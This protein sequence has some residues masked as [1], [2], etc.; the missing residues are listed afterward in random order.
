MK[1][2]FSQHDLLKTV[3]GKR[4]VLQKKWVREFRGE[5]NERNW[6]KYEKNY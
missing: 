5:K 1:G 4:A 2:K 6:Q 3:E